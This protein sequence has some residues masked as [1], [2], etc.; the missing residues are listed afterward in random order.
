[1]TNYLIGERWEMRDL[2]DWAVRFNKM[3]IEEHHLLGTQHLMQDS[4]FDT[5]QASRELWAFLNLNLVGTAHA[6][7]DKAPPLNGFDV[8][9][10][11]V[12]PMAP[13]S[14]ARRVDLHT[15]LHNPKAARTLSELM[16][17]IESWEN[18]RDRYYEMGGAASAERRAMCYPAQNVSSRHSRHHGHGLGGVPGLRPAEKEVREAD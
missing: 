18:L 17:T 11:V 5:L 8:W 14:V 9:R 6:K 12:S 2:L 16:D 4:G 15:E 7:F 10:R 3:R 1:M 13:K